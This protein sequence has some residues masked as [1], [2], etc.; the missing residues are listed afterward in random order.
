MEYLRS[1]ATRA[2]CLLI[3]SLQY[4]STYLPRWRRPLVGY[5]VGVFLVAG[6]LALNFICR[7]AS[8]YI[9]LPGLGLYLYSATLIMAI[10]WGLGPSLL[11]LLA[12]FLAVD[13]FYIQPM[14]DAL[15]YD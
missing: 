13:Y 5:T 3:N 12:S 9:T 2:H 7:S 1:F 8:L 14:A 6:A 11:V 15:H 10:C 4:N